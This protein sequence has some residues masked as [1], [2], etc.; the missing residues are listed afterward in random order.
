[1]KSGI[2]L[3][4]QV[5]HVLFHSVFTTARTCVLIAVVAAG[6]C[7]PANQES[8]MNNRPP[9]STALASKPDGAADSVMSSEELAERA[10]RRRGVETMIWGMP[11]VNFQRMY[12]A[13]VQQKGDFNQVVYWSK[14]PDWKNQTLTPNPDVIYLMPFYDT[15]NGPMVLEIPPSDGGSITGS[16]D[17][18]WQ[19]AIE[20]VGPA[21]LDKGKGGRYLILPPHFKGSVPAGYFP[22]QSSTF[23]GYALLRSNIG[24]G[25]EDD[26][27]KAAAY[28]RRV[29]LY[30]L[31]QAGDPPPT[32]FVDALGTEFDS[33]I[34]YDHR[35]FEVLQRFVERE[36]WLERDR[37]MIDALKSLGIEKGKPYAPSA[38]NQHLL[39]EAAAEAKAWLEARY[40]AA[41]QPY[42]EGTQWALPASAS[43]LEAISSNYSNPNNYPIDDRG[44]TYSFAFFSAKHL[45]DGQFYLMSIADKEGLPLQGAGTYRL[46]V[47][48]NAPVKLYWS[49]TV[50]DRHSHALVRGQK[51]SSRA[52]T[53]QGLKTNADGSI[54]IDF[55]P[56]AVEGA[57]SNWI[58]TGGEGQFEVLFRFYGPE[59][60]LFDKTWQL[61]DIEKLP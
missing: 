42:N 27:V 57:E 13:M 61:P 6:G 14:L 58:P 9:T 31:A 26:I 17:D 23:S 1:M 16:L 8:A 49:A 35:F 29:Q 28:G 50:Y 4:V 10:I 45:G 59:K 41:F 3:G 37:A 2:P 19:T 52:S 22:M 39:D 30:P 44:L 51:W 18:G 15:R 33:T 43:F 32:R 34:Q 24:S 21:G 40:T 54:D 7:K 25:S 60:A 5:Q 36:P 38:E 46:R 55:G 20:D 53:T 48:A 47:P 12:E 11:A 56:M